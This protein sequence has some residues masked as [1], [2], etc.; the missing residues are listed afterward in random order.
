MLADDIAR[1]L[2][3]LRREA[4]ARML[5]TAEI[6]R[7]TG[8]MTQD[9]DTGSETPEYAAA[10]TTACRVSAGRGLAVRDAEVGGRTI[11]EA[12]RELHIPV[13]SPEVLPDDIAVITAVHA[14][15]DPTL[16]NATLTFA[17]AAPGSQTTAR[18]LQVD[19]VLS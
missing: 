13:D 14:T 1:V 16:L 15:S 7:K 17:G 8:N 12:T 10:F 18:R 11:A 6:R 5:D 9:P 2:P 3:E 19:E 4:E